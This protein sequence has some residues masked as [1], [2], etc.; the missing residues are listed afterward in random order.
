VVPASYSP[1][2]VRLALSKI[3]WVALAAMFF[4]QCFTILSQSVIPLIAPV[5]LPVLDVP[6]SYLGV[7]V[8]I[9]AVAKTIVNIGCGNFIRRYG[10]IRISQAGLVF[11]ILALLCAASGYVWPFLITAIA[12]ALG[13]AAGTPASSH[14]LSRYAPPRY[15]PMIFSAKQTSVPVGL[16][17]GGLVVPYLVSLFGWQGALMA[18]ATMCLCFGLFLQTIRTEIDSDRIPDQKMSV[19]D[20]H[21]TLLVV[22]RHRGLLR[23]SIVNLSFVGL[24]IT[25][26]TY[27]VLFLTNELN[28]SYADAGIFYATAMMAA[29][30]ARVLWGYV[31]TTRIGAGNVLA[32]LALGMAAASMATGMTTLEWPAW[33]IL[34]VSIIL[35]STALGWQGVLLSEVARLAP[36][37][38]I[39]AA[40]GGVLGF[41][42]IGQILMPL[43]FSGMLMLTGE[44]RY[45]FMV[46]AIPALMV[47]VMLLLGG[48]VEGSNRKHRPTT[49]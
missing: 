37:G 20:F 41:S 17:F 4:Q 12:I 39:G 15:A 13:T 40:T 3:L 1:I 46:V 38:Q 48:G 30:P 45:G 9:S 16:A 21:I 43:A 36:P 10:G 28:Y 35:T 22:L 34:S 2:M 49:N 42:S 14:I 26:M 25:Y 24:Q 33:Q 44:Y 19:N 47:A 8:S 6:A 32:G 7:F 11:V 31:A 23:L 5:A 27:M 29:I 18:I